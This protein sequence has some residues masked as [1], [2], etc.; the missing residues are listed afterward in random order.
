MGIFLQNVIQTLPEQFQKKKKKKKKKKKSIN[1]KDNYMSTTT[2]EISHHTYKKEGQ[3][4]GY[5]RQKSHIPANNYIS[6]NPHTAAKKT[7]NNKK[8]NHMN[9]KKHTKQQ[10][11]TK[12]NYKTKPTE[13]TN[14]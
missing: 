6:F 5:T 12:T 10:C 4:P 2:I 13:T 9:T 11:K 1:T 8:F 14:K 3:T 7:R